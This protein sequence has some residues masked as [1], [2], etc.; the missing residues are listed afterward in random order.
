MHGTDHGYVDMVPRDKQM[1][2]GQLLGNLSDDALGWEAVFRVVVGPSSPLLGGLTPWIAA[3]QA[4]EMLLPWFA[5]L[6]TS[7][8]SH[9]EHASSLPM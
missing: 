6:P 4:L 8:P 1:S 3:A 9:L 2:R 5:L 7:P